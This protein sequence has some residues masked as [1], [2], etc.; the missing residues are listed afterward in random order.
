MAAQ[1]TLNVHQK[2][3]QII[4]F[5]FEEKPVVTFT[6]N[7]LVVTSTKAEARYQL[8]TVAKFTF[9]VEGTAVE[10]IK[11]DVRTAAISLDEYVVSLTGAKPEITVRLIA[12]DGKVLQ[13]YKTDR[14][15]Y[16]QFSI[17]DLPEGTYIIS[18]ESLNVKI[19]KK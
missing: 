9:D 4:S 1:N 6:D 12:S 13:S 17:A 19:L 2:D 3:G 16:V 8:A 10:G 5:G 11:D 14:N 7:E 18:S 15:G